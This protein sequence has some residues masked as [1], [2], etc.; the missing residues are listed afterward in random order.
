MVEVFTK[1][2][3]WY[4]RAV[5][6]LNYVL[7]KVFLHWLFSCLFVSFPTPPCLN[8]SYSVLG[9]IDDGPPDSPPPLQTP[10]WVKGRQGGRVGVKEVI[11]PPLAVLHYS[12]QLDFWYFLVSEVKEV[13]RPDPLWQSFP[14]PSNFVIAFNI[15]HSPYQ[16][17]VE[18]IWRKIVPGSSSLLWS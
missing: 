17:S 1:H 3:F 10:T 15:Q 8:I 18:L 12:L 6:R 5:V 14:I 11:R 4:K 2:R 9:G 7:Q 13:I 16:Y